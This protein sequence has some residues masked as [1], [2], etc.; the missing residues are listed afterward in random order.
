VTAI[1]LSTNFFM[2]IFS[3]NCFLSVLV[4]SS[5]PAKAS[6]TARLKPREYEINML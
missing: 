3:F 5:A 4:L 1:R 6:T 2:V